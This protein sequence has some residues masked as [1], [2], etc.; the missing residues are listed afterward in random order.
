MHESFAAQLG[1]PADA[2]LV[3]LHAD[4]VG[5]SHGS[6]RAFLELAAAGMVKSGSIM[7]PCPWSAEILALLQEHPEIDVGVHLTLTSEWPG[8]RWGPLTT[9]KAGSGLIRKD[10]SFWPS[11]EDVHAQ[12]DTAYAAV[13]LRAQV[14]RV[15]S[16]GIAITHLDSHMGVNFLSALFDV[17]VA[18]GQDYR[19]PVF[20]PRGQ[21][22]VMKRI[23]TRH[24]AHHRHAVEVLHEHGFPPVDYVRISPCYTPDAPALPSADVYEAVLR[25]LEPGITHFALHPNASGDIEGIDPRQGQ[26][27][28]FEYGYFQSG[29]LARFLEAEGIIPIGYRDLCNAMRQGIT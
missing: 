17:Y 8:Y 14:E 1:Y 25:G 24:E 12:A 5:M 26:W 16:A 11:G 6:N 13:E 9:R 22:E 4:D 20:Y 21:D 27:R 18:L 29:R 7:A 3:I 2:R 10:G 23:W 15:V 19:V 28:V